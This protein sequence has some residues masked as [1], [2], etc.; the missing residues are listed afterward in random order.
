MEKSSDI[1]TAYFPLYLITLCLGY[2][3]YRIV[4]NPGSRYFTI[5]KSYIIISSVF[6]AF[7]VIYLNYSWL[8]W[9]KGLAPTSLLFQLGEIALHIANHLA[10]TTQMILSKLYAN[11]FIQ[12]FNRLYRIELTLKHKFETEIPYHKIIFISTS[13]IF[14]SNFL[15]IFELIHIMGDALANGQYERL[16][17]MMCVIYFILSVQI[18]RGQFLNGVLIYRFLF[19]ETRNYLTRRLSSLSPHI[20]INKA[21]EA[22]CVEI[23]KE[24]SGIYQ[25]L[26]E[27]LQQFNRLLSVQ[28]LFDFAC[29]YFQICISAFA[30]ILWFNLEGWNNE[31]YSN[32]VLE[33]ACIFL[34]TILKLLASTITSHLCTNEMSQLSRFLN[35]ISALKSSKVKREVHNFALQLLHEKIEF[36]AAGFFD[37]DVKVI[38]SVAATVTTYTILLVQ[39]DPKLNLARIF[40]RF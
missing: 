17:T 40:P 35:Q 22:I 18:I 12:V 25:D 10:V 6:Q 19:T 5:W 33:S 21:D 26:C 23:L 29:D 13:V 30:W 36:T 16:L 2:A 32:V 24:S 39:F 28:L 34:A 1:F 14:I 9:I 31:S 8:H 37:I 27:N 4:E 11:N 38:F 3:P 20:F 15:D 7:M